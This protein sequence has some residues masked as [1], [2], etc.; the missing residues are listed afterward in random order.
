[1][2][3]LPGDRAVRVDGKKVAAI[4]PS[5]LAGLLLKNQKK[6]A[7]HRSDRFLEALYTVYAEVVREDARGA[8]PATVPSSP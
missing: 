2:R 8:R 6:P 1:M 7:R 4:R 5:H 3:I